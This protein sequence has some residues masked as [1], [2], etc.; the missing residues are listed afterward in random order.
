MFANKQD[1]SGALSEQEL[2]VVSSLR[3]EPTE[4]FALNMHIPLQALGLDDIHNH[5]W[6]IFSC[7]AVTGENLLKGMDWVVNDVA[8]RIYMMD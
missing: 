8:S 4:R 3:E 6:A 5:H 7:S 1:L 2:R